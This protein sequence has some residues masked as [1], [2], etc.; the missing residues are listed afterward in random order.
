MKNGNDAALPP[1]ALMLAPM[2]EYSHGALRALIHEFG[3]CDRYYGE[4]CGA[5]AYLSDAPYDAWFLDP[6]PAPERS[7]MQFF[8]PDE[9]RMVA[10]VRKLLAERA[11]AG[12]PVGGVDLNFGCAAPLIE[13]QGG[14]V[15]W[16]K[17]PAAAAAM[18]AA[19]RRAAD[20]L[21]PGLSISAKMRL[22]YDESAEA[23]LSFANGLEAAGADYLVLHPRL[24][25]Q[26]FRR[27][28]KWDYVALLS[29]E[30]SIPIIGNGDVR[31]YEGYSQAVERYGAAGVM[32]GRE[33]V[34]R[35][36]V[37]A[38][39]RGR[40]TAP[41]YSIEIGLEETGLRMMALIRE[42]LPLEFHLSRAKR[43]FFYYC[44]NLSFS[45]HLRFAIQNAGDLAAIERLFRA[46]FDEVPADRL[47]VET[48]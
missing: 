2:V 44:D 48:A 34:R 45:H 28:G 24:K 12:V 5:P 9:P 39:I 17:D 10:A 13:K 18:T 42:R 4:M 31:G 25:D 33:A 29:R 3:G 40:E 30:L 19:V 32:I 41:D 16:M 35:P 26:K 8:S 15:R 38:L 6:Y 11:D 14:G 23:L 46:Y 22:G 47:R 43:F 21:H 20:E 36:W 37:F 7:V 1:G 27:Q